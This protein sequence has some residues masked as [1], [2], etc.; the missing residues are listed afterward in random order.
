MAFLINS[1]ARGYDEKSAII[2]FVAKE[3]GREGIAELANL[4]GETPGRI[5]QYANLKRF[6]E[7]RNRGRRQRK[8]KPRIKAGDLISRQISNEVDKWNLS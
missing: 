5:E 7:D 3:K 6:F 2:R 1:K 4:I 8:R